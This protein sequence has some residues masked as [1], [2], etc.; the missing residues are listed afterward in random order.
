MEFLPKIFRSWRIKQ[1]LP[2]ELFRIALSWTKN[3]VFRKMEFEKKE[4]FSLT[5]YILTEML[6]QMKL[7][8]IIRGL[9]TRHWK[10]NIL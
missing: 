3:I 6:Q 7:F 4:S 10:L 8:G 5:K 9:L 1:R 2:K